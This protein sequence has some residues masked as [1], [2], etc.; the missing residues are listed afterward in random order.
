M[1]FLAKLIVIVFICFWVSCLN[2]GKLYIWTD[3]NGMTHI[4]DQPPPN[5][6]KPKETMDV[7]KKK[8]N[9]GQSG[10]SIES[11]YSNLPSYA[12]EREYNR[13]QTCVELLNESNSLVRM[14]SKLFNQLA[15]NAKERIREKGYRKEPSPSLLREQQSISH[16]MDEISLRQKLIQA[17]IKALNCKKK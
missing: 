7:I 9:Y 1:K 8:T 14:R 2:A 5:E 15:N 3:E 17:K 13:L 6:I 11:D 12:I 10:R 4:S 16:Q